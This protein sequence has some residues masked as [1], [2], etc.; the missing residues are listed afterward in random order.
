MFTEKS[1]SL[2]AFRKRNVQQIR[3]L[4][5]KWCFLSLFLKV[6]G[7]SYALVVRGLTCKFNIILKRQIYIYICIL[8]QPILVSC[9]CPFNTQCLYHLSSPFRKLVNYLNYCPELK[10]ASQKVFALLMS[11]TRVMSTPT[12]AQV[13]RVMPSLSSA[14]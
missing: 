13:I 6:I 5:G 9:S 8:L 14:L 4:T 3:H 2:A 1:A 7:N 11:L 12:L 10:A